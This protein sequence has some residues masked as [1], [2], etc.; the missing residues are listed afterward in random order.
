MLRAVGFDDA[1]FR[2]PQVGIASTQA[3]TD[4]P[5]FTLRVV[6]YVMWP[7]QDSELIFILAPNYCARV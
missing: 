2:K 4:H 6:H 1:D 3:L 7:A 5:R